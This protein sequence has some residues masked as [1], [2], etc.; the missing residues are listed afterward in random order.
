MDGD[1]NEF[2][3]NQ[4]PRKAN[5]ATGHCPLQLRRGMESNGVFKNGPPPAGNSNSDG[6]GKILE[7][8]GIG[9]ILELD[10]DCCCRSTVGMHCGI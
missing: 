8:D 10:D 2:K 4:E 6:I 1:D 5:K 9:E 3:R 7:I